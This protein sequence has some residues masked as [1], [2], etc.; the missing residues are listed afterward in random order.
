MNGKLKIL[1]GG[2]VKVSDGKANT[3]TAAI[4]KYM[5]EHNISFDNLI[6]F[7]SDGANTMVA[8]LN[9]V[10]TQLKNMNPWIV[11]VQCAAHKLALD[12]VH[13]AKTMPYLL[14][15]QRPIN[16][17]YYGTFSNIPLLDIRKLR[18]C[19]LFSVRKLRNSKSLQM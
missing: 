12:V 18:N 16:S 13:G 5:T 17:V 7:A 14:E 11:S 3:I 8:R 4:L 15:M 2:N 9:G 19:K 6:G 10:S 1:F